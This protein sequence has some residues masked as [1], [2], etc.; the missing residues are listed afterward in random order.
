MMRILVNHV[1]F[2]A[3][4]VKHALVQTDTEKS[5]WL[6]HDIPMKFEIVEYGT[7]KVCL[8]GFCENV[9]S[10]EG[11]K[12]WEFY[13][14]S[15][16]DFTV[17]GTYRIKIDFSEETVQSWPFEIRENLFVEECLSD[18]LFYLK[19]QRCSG[20]VDNHDC[21]IPFFGN[22][23]DRVDVHGGWYDASGDY[24][25][26]LSHLSYANYLNPQQTPAVV[27]ALLQGLSFIT[28]DTRPTHFFLK[29]RIREEAAWGADFLVRMQDREGYFYITVFDGWSHEPEKRMI[30]S[31]KTQE[32]IRGDDYQAGIR[33]GAGM[34]IAALARAYSCGL[35][36]GF[37]A[38]VYLKTAERGY[39]HLKGK[40]TE[41][42]DDGR[43]NIIDHYCGLLAATELYKATGSKSYLDDA[44]ERVKALASCQRRFSDSS[45]Y[46]VADRETGRPYYHPAEAGL[47]LIALLR[48][49]DVEE[50]IAPFRAAVEVLGRAVQFELE[51]TDEVNNPFGYARQYI[52]PLNGHVHT[53]FFMPRDN[54]TGYWWQGE[55][56]RIASLAAAM[57]WVAANYQNDHLEAPLN[58]QT[59]PSLI[60]YATNQLN[61]ILGLNP[62]DTCMMDGHGWNNPEYEKDFPNA[63]GGICNGVTGG[64]SDDTGIDFLPSSAGTSRLHRWRW[65]EQWLPHAAWF[66]L[67]ICAEYHCRR[68]GAEDEG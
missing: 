40:N 48:Y 60:N 11:W 41:Y 26:Y 64:F 53:S 2:E 6:N 46:W 38:E 45:N 63:P 42:L 5:V 8:A 39:A 34:A 10:V 9:G 25:K 19:G 29:S 23:K 50:D 20:E 49:V 32:G 37:P 22:R 24:S 1:G 47:P 12:N 66:F 62:Y 55:N 14:L 43:E 67:A 15:F 51:V 31:F 3:S 27:W 17:A 21:N 16:N 54:E 30:S 61:W 44:R 35:K 59:V 7:G 4:G 36:G 13:K 57:F 28:Q 56:A 18:I 58:R 52:K 65:S 68:G 33:Q